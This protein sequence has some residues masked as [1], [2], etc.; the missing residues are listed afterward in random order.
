MTSYAWVGRTRAGQIVKGERAADSSEALTQALR[1]EQIL[2]TKVEAAQ[3]KERRMR[4]VAPRS[5]AIFTRQ[6][7]VMIDAG[8]ELTRMMR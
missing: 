7:S 2:V 4:R 5:L 3:K 8:L 6:F 1:R